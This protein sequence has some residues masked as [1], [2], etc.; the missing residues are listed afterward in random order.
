M[1]PYSRIQ[2]LWTLKKSM[3]KNHENQNSNGEKKQKNLKEVSQ[4]I[5]KENISRIHQKLRHIVKIRENHFEIR[6]RKMNEKHLLN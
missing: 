1:I 4:K 5:K 6:F 3:E 2:N